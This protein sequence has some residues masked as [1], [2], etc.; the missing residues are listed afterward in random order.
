[1]GVP[2][3]TYKITT[4]LRMV[5]NELT[6]NFNNSIMLLHGI[7]QNEYGLM[8]ISDVFKDIYK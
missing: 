6:L 4:F 8:V 2:S 3:K 5:Q 7:Y 1:M